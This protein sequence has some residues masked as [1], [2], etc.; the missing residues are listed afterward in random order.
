MYV[1]A[2]IIQAGS[3]EAEVSFSTLRES[4]PKSFRV[5]PFMVLLGALSLSPVEAL[6]NSTL[7]NSATLL[8][9]VWF[10]ENWLN[11]LK[12]IVNRVMP[13]VAANWKLHHINAP[14]PHLLCNQRLPRPEHHLNSSPAPLQSQS[15]HGSV[16]PVPSSQDSTQMI[17]PWDR[18]RCQSDL[19]TLLEGR[20]RK[21]LQWHPLRVDNSLA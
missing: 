18:S 1:A 19:E 16:Y 15:C 7:S 11:R 8:N 14:R 3:M 12:E 13:R 17:T 4:V 21:I 2:R 10:S 9:Y 5:V 20:S 6:K